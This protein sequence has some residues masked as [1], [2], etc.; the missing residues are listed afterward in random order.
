M[1]KLT[2]SI[3][4]MHYKTGT[5]WHSATFKLF[6][7]AKVIL[8]KWPKK[9]FPKAMHHVLLLL[10]LTRH[11]LNVWYLV[12]ACFL[13]FLHSSSSLL[14]LYSHLLPNASYSNP[15]YLKM[16]EFHKALNVHWFNKPFWPIR[17]GHILQPRKWLEICK[18]KRT[19][20]PSTLT[21][22]FC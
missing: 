20:T 4:Q 22:R 6:T 8:D 19:L 21:D 5:L 13:G 3:M 11:F 12:G 17:T 15:P 16:A 10:M 7:S 18:C 1:C 2:F 9:K 14:V